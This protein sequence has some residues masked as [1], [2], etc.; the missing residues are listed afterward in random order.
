VN[1]KIIILT[2]QCFQDEEYLYCYYRLTEEGI[3]PHICTPT[4]ESV[5]G[6]YG[7]PTKGYHV[8]TDILLD[9]LNKYDGVLIPGGFEAPGR[10]RH[11]SEVC[12]FVN[13]MN[14]QNKPIGA[15]CHGPQVLISAGVVNG[16]HITSYKDVYI[17]LK[18]AGAN[19]VYMSPV[20]V[21]GNIVTSSHYDYNGIFMKTFLE[22]LYKYREENV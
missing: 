5:V 1:K 22:V 13:Y 18:N 14:N 15:I 9:N 2:A 10:L 12:K 16:R 17:D 3:I 4:G 6:K 21:D 8:S 11:L 7:V 20:V 19:A